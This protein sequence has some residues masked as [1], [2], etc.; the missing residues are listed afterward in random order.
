[1]IDTTVGVS[2]NNGTG[3]LES[4]LNQVMFGTGMED[5]RHENETVS[6]LSTGKGGDKGS[7]TIDTGPYE[8]E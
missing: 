1:M 5:A 4:F 8:R 3:P 7:S 2:L 6:P